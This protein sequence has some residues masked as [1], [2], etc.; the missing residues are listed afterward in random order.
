MKKKKVSIITIDHHDRDVFEERIG[1][2][3]GIGYNFHGF[4]TRDVDSKDGKI[5]LS[6]DMIKINDVEVD[7]G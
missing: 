3:L 1:Y 6:Q 2:L 7:A 4:I 5:W